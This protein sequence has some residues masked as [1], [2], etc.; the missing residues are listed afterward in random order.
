MPDMGLSLLELYYPEH[1]NSAS[2]EHRPLIVMYAPA[3]MMNPDITKAQVPSHRPRVFTK[4]S[5][6]VDEKRM[7]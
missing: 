6:F 5:V 4:P 3:I 7:K 2:I 1:C